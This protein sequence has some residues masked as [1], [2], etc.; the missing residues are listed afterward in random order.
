MGTCSI[1]WIVGVTLVVGTIN[2]SNLA[3]LQIFHASFFNFSSLL[4]AVNV[5]AAL[6]DFPL[7]NI[8]AVT[9]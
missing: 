7:S 8:E 5:S 1:E 3:I 9:G 6:K 4:N 2:A